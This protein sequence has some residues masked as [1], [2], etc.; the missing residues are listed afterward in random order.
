MRIGVHAVRRYKRRIGCRTASKRRIC[1]L[2]NKEIGKNTVRKIHNKATGQYRIETSKFVA[3]CEKGM[4]ITI[5]PL[6][7][8]EQMSG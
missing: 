8:Q 2:I 5:I 3:V 1:D 7:E 6:C 4:V